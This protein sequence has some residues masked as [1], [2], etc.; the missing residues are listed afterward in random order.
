M[1]SCCGLKCVDAFH[2]C[3]FDWVTN[4][5]V[6]S[7]NSECVKKNQ[8]IFKYTFLHIL[9]QIVRLISYRSSPWFGAA[10]GKRLWMH[11]SGCPQ[12]VRSL[13]RNFGPALQKF[14]SGCPQKSGLWNEILDLLFRNLCRDALRSQVSETKFWTFSSEISVGMPS[15]VRSLK[16]NFGPAVQK[17]VSGCPQKAGI[18]NE[19]LGLLFRN[20]CRDA[21]R[22]Q[23]SEA[24]FWTCCSE[25]CVGMPSEV[26]SLKR[27][28]GPAVQKFV[29]GCPQKSGLWNEILDLLFR[30]LF[31]MGT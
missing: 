21:L 15:E 27:N 10:Q 3:S 1:C 20:L 22:S 16:R 26:R 8:I 19:T 17:F 29:S 24:K 7:N 23:V 25:I 14:M 31:E 11:L 30:N 28:F 5:S 2:V 9:L 6:S 18:W 13:K 12:E 4:G